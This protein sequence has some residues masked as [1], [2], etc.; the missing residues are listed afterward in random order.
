MCIEPP[1]LTWYWGVLSIISSVPPVAV[2]ITTE[3]SCQVASSQPEGI[4]LKFRL[5]LGITSAER[6]RGRDNC[7]LILQM[8][9]TIIYNNKDTL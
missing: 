2:G 1:F 9:I 4:A 7:I 6:E 8:I 3:D 5:V